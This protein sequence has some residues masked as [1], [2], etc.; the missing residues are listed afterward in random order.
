MRPSSRLQ[1][2][3]PG[4]QAAGRES[5]PRPR[6][7]WSA[8][9]ARSGWRMLTHSASGYLHESG[10][11]WYRV[12]AST[13]THELHGTHSTARRTSFARRRPRRPFADRRGGRRPARR[14]DAKSRACGSSSTATGSRPTRSRRWSPACGACASVGGAIEV[15][16]ARRRRSA[17]RWRSTGSTASSRFR[18]SRTSAA[19]SG[20]GPAAPPRRRRRSRRSWRSSGV[21]GVRGSRSPDRSRRRSWPRSRS[22]TRA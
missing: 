9:A 8:N 17:T 2:G 15:A 18:W 22:A 19:S 6:P 16:P 3:P 12:H 4:L 20:R 10:S 5:G 11:T 14:R 1:A 21:P 7:V 13:Y